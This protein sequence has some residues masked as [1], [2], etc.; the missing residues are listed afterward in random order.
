MGS[1]KNKIIRL[2]LIKLYGHICMLGE[3]ISK[4]NYLTLHHILAQ[5]DKGPTTIDNGALLSL[6][7]HQDFNFIE[8]WYYNESEYINEYLK[9]YK[10]TCDELER[11]RMNEY[12]KKLVKSKTGCK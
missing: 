6:F 5:R 1:N 4:S 7:M 10:E 9:Y 12:V 2:E 11:K 8:Q 3:P